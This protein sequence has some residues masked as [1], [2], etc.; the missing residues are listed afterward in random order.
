MESKS[1]QLAERVL[2]AE[3]AALVS[4]YEN[5]LVKPE[6]KKVGLSEKIKSC[7]RPLASFDETFRTAITFLANPYK[8]WK[9]GNLEAR[10]LVLRLA[11]S[12]QL[13][14]DRN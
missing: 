7:G 10:R 12:R 1:T 13:P 9:N 4:V 8:I 3:S 6:E 5:Q 11:F 2:N 14:H